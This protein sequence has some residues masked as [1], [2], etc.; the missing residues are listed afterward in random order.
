MAYYAT[1]DARDLPSGDITLTKSGGGSITVTPRLLNNFNAYS[2]QTTFFNYL[3]SNTW[4]GFDLAGT[5]HLKALTQYTFF[6]ALMLNLRVAASFVG[7]PSP[8]TIDVI[9]NPATRRVTVS[10]PTGITNITFA[11]AGLRRLFGFASDFS[12]SSTSVAG[13]QLPTYIVEPTID[14][15]SSASI[16]FERAP[17]SSLAYSATGRS[18]SVA[19]TVAPMY[20]SWV[21]QYETR[22]KVFQRFAAGA[23]SE[24]TYQ[25]LF[26]D[27][28]TRLPFAVYEGFNDSTYSAYAFEKNED[29]FRPMPAVPGSADQFHIQ[30]RTLALANVTGLT[31]DGDFL[32]FDGDEVFF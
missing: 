17:V 22:A 4:H 6:E 19:R 15:A 20:R 30:F 28:R 27:C 3:L 32:T 2:A 24:Y 31:F 9:F 1:F 21:Q 26:E 13:T 11:N 5:S 29:S 14:G 7:W 8:T 10:Y 16:V 25:D 12:G 23:P 18:Y